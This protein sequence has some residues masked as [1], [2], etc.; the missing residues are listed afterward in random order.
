MTEQ[1]EYLG[2]EIG[3]ILATYLDDCRKTVDARIRDFQ[4]EIINQPPEV[5]DDN[6]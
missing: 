4:E 2:N 6:E 5:A 1:E 3:R